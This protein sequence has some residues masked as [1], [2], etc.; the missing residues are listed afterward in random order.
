M[1]NEITIPALP[2]VSINETLEFYVALGFEITYQ[3]T[4]PNIYGCVKRDDIDLHFFAMKGIDPANSYSTCLVLIT[5]ANSLYQSFAQGLRQHYGKLPIAGI[6]RITKPSN[7]N[8]AGDYRFN[9]VD[10]GGNYIRFI[11][12]NS[13]PDKPIDTLSTATAKTPLGRAIKS[14]DLIVNANSDFA[15]A[16]KILDK[17][18]E[19]STPAAEHV[20]YVKALVLRAEIAVNM[21]DKP[22][23]KSLLS[24]IDELS[25]TDSQQIAL[26]EELLRLAEL[27]QLLV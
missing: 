11:Q 2:C 18:L 20:E 9:V 27:S 14:A 24:R 3:Q 19:K 22:L 16:A 7:K 6:P 8:S 17:A 10:P 4:R 13:Q 15:S 12:Q 23:A 26:E 5:D 21:A 25:L 1:A